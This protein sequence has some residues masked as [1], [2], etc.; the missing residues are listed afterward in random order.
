M[1]ILEAICLSIIHGFESEIVV[2]FL[3]VSL[4]WFDSKGP[5]NLYKAVSRILIAQIRPGTEI[6]K[7]W[8]FWRPFVLVLFMVLSQKCFFSFSGFFALV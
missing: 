7:I 8:A 3:V 5:S 6:F 2:L 1:G 4:L